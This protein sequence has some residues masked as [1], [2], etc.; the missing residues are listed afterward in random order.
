MVDSINLTARKLSSTELKH[1][2][3]RFFRLV[4]A[5]F[6]HEKALA[7]LILEHKNLFTLTDAIEI[8]E[9]KL[10]LKRYFDLPGLLEDLDNFNE[11]PT[12]FENIGIKKAENESLLN[13]SPHLAPNLVEGIELKEISGES[14]TSL[15]QNLSKSKISPKPEYNTKV[16]GAKAKIH[17][18]YVQEILTFDEMS[19]AKEIFR[20]SIKNGQSRA[21]SLSNVIKEFNNILLPSDV[22]FISEDLDNADIYGA[23]MF[24]ERRIENNHIIDKALQSLNYKALNEDLIKELKFFYKYETS[25]KNN[26]FYALMK[27]FDFVVSREDA[28]RIAGDDL[29]EDA[30][31]S[32]QKLFLNFKGIKVKRPR[33][34]SN[35]SGA[36]SIDLDGYERRELSRRE[37]K[38]AK[39]LYL[40]YRKTKTKVE[41][42][43][44]LFEKLKVN[45][46]S[47]DLKIISD[48][49]GLGDAT[50]AR[51]RILNGLKES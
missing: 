48:E 32:A 31:I 16:S 13:E 23:R 42:L 7:V 46:I 38:L 30:L 21:K 37:I 43:K 47:K 49:I 44:A 24:I 22:K 34:K 18:G 36:M 17:K 41:S 51:K 12:L 35:V 29:D 28:F 2:K 45:L 33:V 26:P 10:S 25:S 40:N 20:N 1:F 11:N 19:K 15:T 9:N 8:T 5:D 4:K 39:I 3:E 50:A 14:D 6:K 27:H